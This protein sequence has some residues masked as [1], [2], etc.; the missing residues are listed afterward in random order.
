MRIALNGCGR[1]GKNIVRSLINMQREQELI[2]INLGPKADPSMIA[3][4]LQYD[5]ILGTYRGS[6]KYEDKR[7]WINNHSIELY[8][9]GSA[10]NLP[11]KTLQIDWAID[12]TGKYCSREK[13]QEH[14]HAGARSVLITAPMEG[15]DITIILGVNDKDFD[16]TKHRIVS[17]GSCTTNAV[18][19]LIAT[20]KKTVSIQSISMTTAHSYTNSQALLDG[21]A[22][23]KDPRRSRAA[24]L[25]IVPSSTGALEVLQKIMP[26]FRG[27]VIGHALRVPVPNVSIIDLVAVTQKAVQ[28]DEL[29]AM[30][31]SAAEEY[32]NIIGVSNEPLVSSDFQGDIRSVIVDLPM[33]T[34][35]LNICK[36]FGWYDNEYGY[37]TRVCDFLWLV[38][39]S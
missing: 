21:V 6:I 30:F 20:L 35:T 1:I 39:S 28:Q 5:S 17:L 13:A 16:H 2:A 34:T 15:D 37:S 23:S 4:T 22:S 3:Y 27:K 14:L 12:A 25:N 11:W 33:T 19:P 29:H 31:Y 18:V 38:H 24:A 9:E 32:P 36:I 8:T 26:E 7:L 10:T